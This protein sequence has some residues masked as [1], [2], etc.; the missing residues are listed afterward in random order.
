V[1][2]VR[3]FCVPGRHVGPVVGT[4]ENGV[5]SARSIRGAYPEGWRLVRARCVNGEWVRDETSRAKVLCCPDHEPR[6]PEVPGSPAVS[7][8]GSDDPRRSFQ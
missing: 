2:P 8:Y 4:V 5:S 3:A 7:P 6:W 1:T